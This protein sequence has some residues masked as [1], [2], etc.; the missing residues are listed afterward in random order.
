MLSTLL[1]PTKGSIQIDGEPLTRKNDRLKRKLSV[2]TQ[3][4]S[5]RQ[6][7]TM[8]EIMEYQGTPLLYAIK[9]NTG[10]FRR[11]AGLLRTAGLPEKEPSGSCPAE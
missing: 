4:Y 1:L 2:V 11:I 10:T 8:D 3:E 6:D 7:M 9:K 5:M